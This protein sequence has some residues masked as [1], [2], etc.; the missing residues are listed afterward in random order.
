MENNN[1]HRLLK[2]II[3]FGGVFEAIMGVVVLLWGDLIIALSTGMQTVPVYPL[4]WRTMGLL[5]IALGTLQIV[6]SLDPQRYIAVPVTAICVRFFLPILTAL[7]VI[8]TPSMGPLLIVSTIFDFILAV[9][10]FIL[11]YRAGMLKM[12]T[13]G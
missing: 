10:T 13:G 8:N 5:A 4:Y 1:P 7:E 9:A 11:L 3:A 6:A 2:G 12:S